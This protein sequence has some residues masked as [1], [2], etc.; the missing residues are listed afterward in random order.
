MI[1]KVQI[2]N[3]NG[4]DSYQLDVA[5]AT[6]GYS[7]VTSFKPEIEDR[8]ITDRN[9]TQNRGKWPTFSYEG[10]MS[11]EIQGR[12]LADTPSHVM[13]QLELLTKSLRGTPTDAISVRR[14]GTLTIR[15]LDKS[16]DWFCFFTI[17]ATSIPI[18]AESTN[19]EYMVTLFSFLPYWTGATS[20]QFFF[21]G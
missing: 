5:P 20:G 17:L 6:S 12:I 9:R 11:I 2:A 21:Y 3:A 8:T 4:V 14:H 10:G 19:I 13:T 15:R 18:T 16:E 7:T 1:S